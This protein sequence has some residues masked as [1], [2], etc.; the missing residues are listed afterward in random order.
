MFGGFMGFIY[1][2]ELWALDVLLHL[3]PVVISVEVTEG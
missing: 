3:I 2:V 1:L